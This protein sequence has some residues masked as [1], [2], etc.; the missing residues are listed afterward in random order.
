MAS[1][2]R[3]TLLQDLEPK[4]R[5]TFIV[6]TTSE[7]IYPG[8]LIEVNHSDRTVKLLE[9]D[10]ES[11]GYSFVGISNSSWQS[12]MPD[13]ALKKNIEVIGVCVV[14]AVLTSGV[15]TI[16]P[17]NNAVEYDATNDDGRLKSWDTGNK[18]IG[19]IWECKTG[20]VTSAKVLIN[21]LNPSDGVLE[22][23]S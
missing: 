15:Y 21:I 2:Y 13:S 5:R 10:T 3:S 7:D 9:D 4:L 16:D 20:T 11:S 6:D 14:Q 23:S 22:A 19:W 12:D 1:T 8:D 18:I 17:A